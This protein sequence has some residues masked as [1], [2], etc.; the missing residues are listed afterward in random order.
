L[1]RNEKLARILVEFAETLGG[2]FSIQEI[3]DHLVQ[4][5]VDMLP[6]TGAGVMLMSGRDLHFGAASNDVIQRIEALQNELHEGLCLEA[7]GSGESVAVDDLV[8]AG[9][10]M[11]CSS[12]SG[13]RG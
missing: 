12:H 7:F 2:D 6:I 9:C 5:I 8:V 1:D 10:R 11:S 3:L 13:S 4:R